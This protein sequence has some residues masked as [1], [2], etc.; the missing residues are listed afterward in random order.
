MKPVTFMRYNSVYPL[1]FGFY[2]GKWDDETFS[3]FVR[4]IGLVDRKDKTQ[5]APPTCP[6]GGSCYNFEMG[7]II[8]MPQQPRDVNSLSILVHECVHAATNA[9]NML[10]F[11]LTESS[12][13]FYTY[14]TQWLFRCGMSQ[15]KERKV[16]NA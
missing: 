15:R 12:D 8:W 5:F 4:R 1:T 14:M 6:N 2:Y 13:E 7:S 9:G 16:L 3:R 10:G 11:T